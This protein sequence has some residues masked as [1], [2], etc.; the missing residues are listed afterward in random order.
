VSAENTPNEN[1]HFLDEN[2]ED[3]PDF[4]FRAR[5][6]AI[7]DD[8]VRCSLSPPHTSKA[9]GFAT[10]N[11]A[12]VRVLNAAQGDLNTP[13][14]EATSAN[15]VRK[16]CQGCNETQRPSRRGPAPRILSSGAIV[17]SQPCIQLTGGYARSR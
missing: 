17:T 11:D 2:S 5:A 1:E 15:L 7:F 4:D 12:Q 9:L 14:V 10:Q 13:D 6:A 16:E 3:L 8:T